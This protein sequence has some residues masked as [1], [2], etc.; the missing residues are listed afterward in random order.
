[1]SFE[2]HNKASLFITH[3]DVLLVHRISRVSER[4]KRTLVFDTADNKAQ[5]LLDDN[6]KATKN[7]S[8][9]QQVVSIGWC[10]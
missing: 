6:I 10:C 7:V 2:Q 8:Q 9:A 3:D 4:L 5:F 1:M